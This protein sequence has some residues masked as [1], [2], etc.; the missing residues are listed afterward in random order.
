VKKSFRRWTVVFP[1]LVL[2]FLAWWTWEAAQQ[3]APWY[4]FVMAAGVT[5]RCVLWLWE[6]GK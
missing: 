3:D 4:A 6:C 2:A 1:L 5:A